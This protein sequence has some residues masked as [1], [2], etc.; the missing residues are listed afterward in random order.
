[1]V[2]ILDTEVDLHYPVEH[3]QHCLLAQIPVRLR[4][5]EHGLVLEDRAEQWRTV[6]SVLDLVSSDDRDLLNLHFLVLPEAA[7]PAERLDDVLAA[8]DGFRPN[9]VALMG[10]EHV[11]VREYRRLLDRFRTD[12]AAAIPLVD[13]DL[14]GADLLDVPVNWCCIAVKDARG[15]LRVFLEAKTHPYHAEELLDRG[16]DLY[17]GKHLWLFRATGSPFN[18]MALVCL[19]YLFR[20]P[21]ESNLR[22]IMDH[23]N[24]LYFRT[25]QTLDVVFVLRCDPKPDHR[26]WTEALTGFYGE[27][28]EETPGIREAV[29]VLANASDE[30]SVGA[31]GGPGTFGASSVVISRR[32]RLAAFDLPEFST[33]DLGGAPLRRLRFRTPTRLYYFNLPPQPSSDPRSARL[34]LKV[35]AVLRRTD[36]GG[37]ER[38]GAEAM[39]EM[40]ELD[41]PPES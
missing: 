2:R 41:W 17:R 15:R 9:T 18:F 40:L 10:F 1:M 19:D 30:S 7:V 11:R 38:V 29:T 3:H 20:S 32:H 26:A 33:D 4:R 31:T 36:A 39:A 22:A 12:N 5:G 13:E 35:H 24:R 37:W 6:R 25:R 27:Y 16:G 23:A 21:F 28:I 8:V 14:R 34:P